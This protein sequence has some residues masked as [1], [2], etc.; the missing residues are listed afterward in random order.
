MELRKHTSYLQPSLLG[1]LILILTACSSLQKDGPPPFD[2]DASN[3][4]NAIP[5]SLPK[6][7][8]GNPDSY[9]VYGH[10]YY[11]LDSAQGYLKRGIASWYGTK[12]HGQ[13]TSSR[14]PYDM[15]GMTAASRTL[16]IP[17]FVKITNL[18]NGHTVVVKVNDR[19]PFASDRVMDV[20][21]AAARK[22]GFANKGTALVEVR[23]I[24]PGAPL[25]A[26]NTPSS[27]T[28]AE[29]PSVKTKAQAIYLQLAAFTKL[30]TAQELQQR[31]QKTVNFPIRIQTLSHW[32][33]PLYRVQVGPLSDAKETIRLKSYFEEQGFN[34]LLTVIG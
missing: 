14:E 23:A 6:S 8:Y 16:P 1:T 33:T 27:P 20:S 13:L 28:S 34:H 17:S 19:G 25:L 32:N 18:E 11:V 4:P 30:D 31:L 15:F 3:I 24:T 5:R 29:K 7:R 9:V 22:L 2:I 21:Y 12:F 10:R 26:D